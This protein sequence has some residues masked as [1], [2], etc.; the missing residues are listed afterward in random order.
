MQHPIYASEFIMYSSVS[1]EEWSSSPHA[2]RCFE[3]LYVLEGRC[4]VVT[5]AGAAVAQPH[6]LILFRPYQ[7][8]AETQLSSV[9]AVV[10]LRFPSEFIAQH[11]VPLPDPSVLPTVTP[12]PPNAAFR[13]ILDQII[14]E[15][16]QR[17]S[18][19]AAMIG[20]YLFQFAVLLQRSLRQHGAGASPAD[21]AHVAELRRLLDQHI[22]SE[23]PI[24]ELARLAHMSESHFSHQVKALLGVAPKAYVREQ[25]IA[26]ARELLRSTT[27]TI[28]EIAATLGYDEPTSFFR[29]FK[30]ATGVT[31]GEFRRGC[32]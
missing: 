29:A 6:H 24:R 28:E 20:A 10:C 13:V 18:Y 1:R 22:A 3:L 23:A 5:A 4:R 21:Q 9:Y 12:L 16:Q 17:D 14:A 31:P 25:R 19:S 32:S 26:R 2:H 15:Y 30:R 27:L 7:W 8:H 11:H